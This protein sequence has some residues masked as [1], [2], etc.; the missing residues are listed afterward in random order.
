MLQTVP[1]SFPT[2]PTLDLGRGTDFQPDYSG[3]VDSSLGLLLLGSRRFDAGPAD[4]RE[5]LSVTGGAAASD[6]TLKRVAALWN[7][8]VARIG[9]AG[10]AAGAAVAAAVALAPE[11]ERDDRAAVFAAGVSAPEP[12][13]MPDPRFV[14]AYHGEAGYLRRLE[15]AVESFMRRS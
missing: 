3:V 2:S 1:E 14:A 5:A 12:A 10:A 7:R 8:P 11:A 9:E 15:R 6:E 4:P 13:V